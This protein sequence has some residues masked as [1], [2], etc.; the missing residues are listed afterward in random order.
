MYLTHVE[1]AL[2]VLKNS[3]D[4]QGYAMVKTHIRIIQEIP[5]SQPSYMGRTETPP[6]FYLNV[7]DTYLLPEKHI[8][9]E[10]QWALQWCTSHII[11]AAA[12]VQSCHEEKLW[13]DQNAH[14]P[15][16]EQ[17]IARCHALKIPNSPCF[18]P[19][20][21][22]AGF[23]VLLSGGDVF[24][25]S[26]H[27]GYVGGLCKTIRWSLQRPARR[28]RQRDETAIARWPT[29][30]WAAIK[31]GWKRKCTLFQGFLS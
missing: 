26:Y 17:Q 18:P 22:G 7:R 30:T 14:H 4:P 24:A 28:A 27:P 3:Q 11:L 16:Y 6:T 31:K 2:T 13:S 23:C 15:C 9:R 1:Q 20:P 19:C 21:T 12:Y 25:V 10:E 5:E 29:K 8:D